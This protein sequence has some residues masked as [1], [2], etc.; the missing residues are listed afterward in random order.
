MNTLKALRRRAGKDRVSQS[1][2]K[3]PPELLAVLGHHPTPPFSDLL[4]SLHKSRH[5]YIGQNRQKPVGP[6]IGLFS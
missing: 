2:T 6:F 4:N 3:I 1:S 5:N